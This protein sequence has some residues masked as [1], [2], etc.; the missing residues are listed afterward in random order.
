MAPAL[1]ALRGFLARDLSQTLNTLFMLPRKQAGQS[2][3]SGAYSRVLWDTPDE[4]SVTCS[5][6]NGARKH[7]LANT[8]VGECRY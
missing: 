5:A 8:R 7:G 1:L 2:S 6:A 3:S 4:E